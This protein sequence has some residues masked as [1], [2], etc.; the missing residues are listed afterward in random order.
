MLSVFESKALV[1]SSK[2]NISGS[3]NIALAIEI[4]CRSQPDSFNH[5]SHTS[6]SNH[7][8]SDSIKSKIL[9]SIQAA[10]ISSIDI[11]SLTYSKLCKIDSLK[12]VVS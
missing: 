3:F 11:P 8:S 1:G 12:I 7:F 5:L 2:I 9:A 10:L 6:V 4:L